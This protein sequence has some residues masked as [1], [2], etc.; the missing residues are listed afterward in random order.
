LQ[1]L[2]STGVTED[3]EDPGIGHK[4]STAEDSPFYERLAVDSGI[5]VA[6]MARDSR[7]RGKTGDTNVTIL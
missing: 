5:K 2:F 3:G 7:S 1:R 4:G 6:M